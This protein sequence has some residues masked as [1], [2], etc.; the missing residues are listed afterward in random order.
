MIGSKKEIVAQSILVNPNLG[1]PLFLKIDTQLETT[2]L[3]TNLLFITNLDTPK[4]FEKSIRREIEIVPILEY[5]WKLSRVFEIKRKEQ[6]VIEKKKGF[7]TKFKEKRAKKKK[8]KK[9]RKKLKGKGKVGKLISESF[10]KLSDVKLIK[11]KPRSYRA[12]PIIPLVLK[13]SQVGITSINSL[14]YLEDE[15]CGPLPHFLKHHSFGYGLFNFYK[16]EIEFELSEDVLDF[17]KDYTFVMFDIVVS[18]TRINYHSIVVTKQEWKN[19]TFVHATDLHLA[20]RNDRLYGIIKKWT[21]SPIKQH[22]DSLIH[23]IA[24]RFKRL[25]KKKVI[26][27]LYSELK[28]PLKKRLVNPNNQFRKYI[29]LMNEKVV[30]NELDFIVLTGDLVDFTLL[31]RF[32]KTLRKITSFKYKHSNWKVFKNIILNLRVEEKYRGVLDGE[33]L[34]CPIFTTLGNHDYRPYH[35]DLTWGGMYRKIG[36]DADEAVALNELFSASPVTAIT[37]TPL[38]LKGYISEI[39][40]SFDFSILLGDNLFVFLNSGSDSFKNFRDLI[41]GHPSVMGLSSK[42]IKYLENLINHMIKDGINTFL[43][44]HGPPINTG[45]KIKIFKR[46]EKKEEEEEGKINIEDYKESIQNQ[47]GINGLAAR[48]DNN[49]N[50]KY[51]TISSNWEKLIEFCK[52]YCVITLAG[53]THLMKEYRLGDADVKT[54]VYDAP[55]FSLKKLENPAAVYYDLYSELYNSPEDIEKNGPY[56]VQTPALGLGGY[57]N[58][59]TVGAYRIVEVKDGKLDSFKVKYIN[60]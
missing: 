59:N 1:H 26:E 4:N 20:E 21:E 57:R 11:L 44:V 35:Y 6:E 23:R 22:V 27:S 51:G 32:F 60:R 14:T 39:N 47:Q 48:I 50:V 16:V 52:N 15:Y 10:Q 28:A 12:E 53:H 42:Q 8:E 34:L 37:K 43:F 55:P 40:P 7:I 45:T 41:S 29:S 31:S 13:V 58:P 17:L 2:T 46:L 19:F 38:A 24:K 25:F 36:I 30:K 9:K 18:K 54:T 56:V 49:F 5:K 33:E 3:Q